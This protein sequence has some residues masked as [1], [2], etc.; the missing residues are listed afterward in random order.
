[1]Y[2]KPK[3]KLG[4]NFLIDKNI[5]RKIINACALKSEDTVLEIGSGRGELTEFIA[6]K[7]ACVY[8]VEID[9]ALSAVLK[10]KFRGHTNVKII[11]RDILELNL[12]RYFSK[13]KNNIKVMGNIPYYIT[14]PIIEHLLAFRDKLGTIFIS[15]QKE[16]AKRIT[17]TPGSK[18]Y[19]AFS[20]FLQYYTHPQILFFIKNNSFRPAPRVDSCLLRLKIRRQPPVKIKNE[21]LF[22]KIIRTAFNQRRKVLK[23]SLGGIVSPQRLN[24]FFKQYKINPNIRPE[25]LGL[26]DFANLTRILK[27]EP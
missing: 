6:D 10:N 3:K 24:I 18:D 26:T 12:R 25:D 21:G 23:N 22:F 1:M 14:T 5:Q 9:A 4:Q 19:G 16:F 13:Y 7:V 8:A 11:K 2:L 15:V 17:A 27:K 20:C